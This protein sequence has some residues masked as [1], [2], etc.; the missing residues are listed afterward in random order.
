MDK[1]SSFRHL[2]NCERAEI[3]YRVRWGVGTS[4]IA[5]LCIHGGDIEP[6]TSEIGEA[7]A[8]EDHTYY[9]LEGL[10]DKGNL[11]LH[12]TSTVFDE[13][14]ALEVICQSD[15][16]ISVHGCSDVE[17]IVYLGGLDIEL[18]Q[19]VQMKLEEAG[20]RAMESKDAGFRGIDQR[21]IC[22]LCGRGM[23]VQLEISRGLR[24]GMFKNLS[25]E[26]RK[27]VEET[28][29]RFVNAVREALDPFRTPVGEWPEL[30]GCE[31]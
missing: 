3:D 15:I 18:K 19:R 10:K 9:A 16:I 14:V 17:E 25:P 6:G 24:S 12:I 7:I 4:G 2:M 20:F 28:F 11:A 26:G 30:A 8:G 22:N 31:E 23:G 21:N 29:H 1:Y 5:V 13:P 27:H